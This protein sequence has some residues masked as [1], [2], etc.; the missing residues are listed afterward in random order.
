MLPANPAGPS[1]DLGRPLCAGIPAADLALV[2]ADQAHGILRGSPRNGPVSQ[3]SMTICQPTDST[4]LDPDVE[5]GSDRVESRADGRKSISRASRALSVVDRPVRCQRPPRACAGDVSIVVVDP[6]LEGREA[7]IA[8]WDFESDEVEKH[9]RKNRDGGS[10]QFELPWPTM[11]Q[12][13]DLRVFVRFTGFDGRRREANLP[14][15]IQTQGP[16][17]AERGWTKSSNP[18]LARADEPSSSRTSSTDDSI[19]DKPDNPPE[20]VSR[21]PAWSPNR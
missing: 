14:I 8:R 3:A 21:R 18:P 7:K 19:Q 13:N 6:Q 12:H 5:V 11:P 17:L 9:V 1:I 15:D 20:P 4:R 16:Q 2:R 10:L